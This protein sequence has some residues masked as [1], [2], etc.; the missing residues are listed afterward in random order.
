MNISYQ[1]SSITDLSIKHVTT[2]TLNKLRKKMDAKKKKKS[3]KK[4]NKKIK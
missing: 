1:Y 2:G 4:K 3:K